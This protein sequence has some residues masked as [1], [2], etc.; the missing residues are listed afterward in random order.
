MKH[1]RAIN[2]AMGIFEKF[3]IDLTISKTRHKAFH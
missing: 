1:L 3:T 2:T